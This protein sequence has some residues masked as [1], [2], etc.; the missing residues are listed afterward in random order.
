MKDNKRDIRKEKLA[1][2]FYEMGMDLDLVERVTNVKKE[3]ILKG[4]N[5]KFIKR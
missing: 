5:D 4:K 3:F 1:K 2:I